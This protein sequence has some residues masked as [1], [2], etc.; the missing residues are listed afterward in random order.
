VENPDRFVLAD[1]DDD[2]A[3][4]RALRGV[5]ASGE[6]Q[7]MLR[8]GEVLVPRIARLP[9]P[10]APALADLAPGEWDRDGTVLITGGT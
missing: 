6:P 10:E 2:E 9:F 1:L 7:A 3:S 4:L 8:S 5:L